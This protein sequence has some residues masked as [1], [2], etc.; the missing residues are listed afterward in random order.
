MEGVEIIT[1]YSPCYPASLNTNLV[2]GTE[3]DSRPLILYCAGNTKILNNSCASIVGSREASEE[4]LKFTANVA[5]R[6]TAEGTVIACGYAKGV[7]KQA[8]DSSIESEGQSIVV[9]LREF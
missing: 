7:D 6:L 8:F 1:L 3:K 9:L 5:E 4:S 2:I